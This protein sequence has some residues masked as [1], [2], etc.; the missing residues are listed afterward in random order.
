MNWHV[1]PEDVLDI[2]PDCGL[3]DCDGDCVIDECLGEVEH[4]LEDDFIPCD[5]CD[6]PGCSGRSCADDF[7]TDEEE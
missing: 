6:D 2:C 5:E 3:L 1:D 7:D 4:E